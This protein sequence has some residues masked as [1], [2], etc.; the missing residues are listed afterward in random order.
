MNQG[1]P[2]GYEKISKLLYNNF[3]IL[4]LEEFVN[5]MARLYHIKMLKRAKEKGVGCMVEG[6]GHCPINM[7]P[8][9]VKKS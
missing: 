9:I 2:L 1:N 5:N 6:I 8:E 4:L 3:R 7:I